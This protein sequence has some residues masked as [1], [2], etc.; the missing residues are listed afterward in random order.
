MQDSAPEYN[1]MQTV[2]RR[3]FAMRNGIIADTL[4]KAGSSF[5]IIFGLNL[6]QIVEIADSTGEN[7]E[8]AEQLWANTTTRESMLLAPMIQCAPHFDEEDAVRWIQTIPAPEV[9][10]ILCHRLLRKQEYAPRLVDI[11]LERADRGDGDVAMQRYTALRLMFNLVAKEPAHALRVARKVAT[12]SNPLTD[13]LALS[14][15][16]EAQ[17]LM[18]A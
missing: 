2:K 15:I 6:P 5:R 1:P 17:F 11:L 7:P 10:D 18:E 4:R 8:L 3:F 16:E 13:N 14:L 9:A 12:L